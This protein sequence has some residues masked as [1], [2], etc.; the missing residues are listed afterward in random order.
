MVVAWVGRATGT[1]DMSVDGTYAACTTAICLKAHSVLGRMDSGVS[2]VRVWTR[3]IAKQLTRKG[4]KFRTDAA[5]SRRRG[6]F[7]TPSGSEH[8]VFARS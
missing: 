1:S 4:R 3:A 8:S 6:C 7:G 2:R 5:S